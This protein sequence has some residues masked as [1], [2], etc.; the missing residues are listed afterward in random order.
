MKERDIRQKMEL[1]SNAEFLKN[2]LP[3]CLDTSVAIEIGATHNRF[4]QP[5]RVQEPPTNT[6]NA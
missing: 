2:V 3:R 6:L 1:R 4:W 5:D